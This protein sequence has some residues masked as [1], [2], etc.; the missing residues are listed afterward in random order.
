[1]GLGVVP[2]SKKN[3]EAE[4]LHDKVDELELNF[5]K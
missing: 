5:I 3:S 1:M 2:G 4:L